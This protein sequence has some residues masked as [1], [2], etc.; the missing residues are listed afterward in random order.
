MNFGQTAFGKPSTSG[1]GAAPTFGSGAVG[2]TGSIFGQ[3][4]AANSTGLFGQPQQT[5]TFGSAAPL[6]TGFCKYLYFYRYE[7][8]F[9]AIYRSFLFAAFGQST[10]SGVFGST[11]TA[12]PSS[13]FNQPAGPSQPFGAKPAG[14]SFGSTNTGG[15]FG[16]GANTGSSLF[17]Q[18][19][20]GTSGTG[21]F[22]ATQGFFNIFI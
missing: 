6:N 8:L 17:G 13:L 2:G 7:Q 22:G 18:P 12:G 19:T 10:S 16:S 21:V 9:A 5:N 3:P 11:P 1:F 4:A 20:A 15:F 14:F